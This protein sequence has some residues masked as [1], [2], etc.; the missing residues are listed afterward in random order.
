MRWM[1]AGGEGTFLELTATETDFFRADITMD[2]DEV[3]ENVP[4]DFPHA[5]LFALHIDGRGHNQWTWMDVW[6]EDQP[7]IQVG[8][9]WLALEDSIDLA[10]GDTIG[11]TPTWDDTTKDWVLNN[12]EVTTESLILPAC[13]GSEQGVFDWSLLELGICTISDVNGV[14]IALETE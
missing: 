14:R 1:T 10:S 6:Y 3:L 8:N 4:L 9:R 5:S 12:P 13:A 11:V 2:R 7:R